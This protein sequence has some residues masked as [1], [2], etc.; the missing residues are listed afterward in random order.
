M[1]FNDVKFKTQPMGWGIQGTLEVNGFTLSV[2]AGHSMYS[3][4]REDLHSPDD[5][6][7]FEIAVFDSNGNWATKTFFPDHC[8]DVKGW[9]SRDE[10]TELIEKIEK[11]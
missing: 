1:T 6:L 9:M 3:T 2:V 7:S 10:I 8:D 11:F 5:F 4:P